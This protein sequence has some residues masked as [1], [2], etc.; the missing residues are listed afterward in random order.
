MRP[1]QVTVAM[2]GIGAPYVPTLV[3]RSGRRVIE[4]MLGHG[5]VSTRQSWSKLAHGAKPVG[6]MLLVLSAA[7]LAACRTPACSGLYCFVGLTPG[8]LAWA[9]GKCCLPGWA[10]GVEGRG[11][12]SRRTAPPVSCRLRC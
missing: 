5:V 2:S 10:I 7:R 1:F 4:I 3:G 6:S 12:Q 11:R 9:G 8:G